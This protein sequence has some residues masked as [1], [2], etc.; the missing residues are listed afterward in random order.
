[1]SRIQDIFKRCRAAGRKAL[2]AYSTVGAPDMKTSEAVI[3]AMIEGGAD[4]IELGV[5]FP[6]RPPTGR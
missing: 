1:M 4:I 5:P 3:G 2:I 6:I